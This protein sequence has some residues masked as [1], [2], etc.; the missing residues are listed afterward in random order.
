M[1]SCRTLLHTRL[2]TRGGKINKYCPLLFIL[3]CF[4]PLFKTNFKFLHRT[5]VWG[6]EKKIWYFH[7][8]ILLKIKGAVKFVCALVY[9]KKRGKKKKTGWCNVI[10]NI[11]C[12][13]YFD[14][15]VGHFYSIDMI[16]LEKYFSIGAYSGPL[17]P[18]LYHVTRYYF[19]SPGII[20]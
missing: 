2:S 3:H 18:D 5:F 20:L 12:K 13:R 19:M 17:T 8:H 16:F 7:H 6:I 1:P 14:F 11:Q 4:L 10:Y 15:S 9:K